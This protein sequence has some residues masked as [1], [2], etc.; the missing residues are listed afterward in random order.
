MDAPDLTGAAAAPWLLALG[1]ALRE[2]V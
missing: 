2:T 1:A